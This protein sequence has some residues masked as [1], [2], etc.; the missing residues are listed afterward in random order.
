[1]TSSNAALGGVSE[2]QE[3]VCTGTAGTFT[4]TFD[5]A[6]SAAIA[7]NAIAADVKTAFEGLSTVTSATV[8]FSSGTSAC[9]AAGAN[10]M[11]ITF[12]GNAGD[13]ALVTANVA[14]LDSGAGTIAIT[15]ATAGTLG[16]LVHA[17][18]TAGSLG[19]L[20]HVEATA[21]A[22]GTLVHAETTAGSL[23]TLVH[24]E[25]TAGT[26]GTLVHAQTTAGS[27]GTL[28]HAETTAGAL[29][30]LAHAQ[31]TAGSLGTLA[32]AE[33]VAGTL[34][35]IVAAET[36]AGVLGTISIAET[37]KGIDG[38]ISVAETAKG[39][40]G[41]IAHV[42]TTKGIA[43]NGFKLTHDTETT[44]LIPFSANAA[45]V[46]AKIDAL[47]TVNTV[48]V[49]FN[50]VN[51]AACAA[52]PGVDI[53]VTFSSD[54]CDE[55][56]LTADTSTGQYQSLSTGL[57]EGAGTVTF[58]EV[59]KGTC[60]PG[61]VVDSAD[62]TRENEECSNRGICNTG[63][64]ECECSR[65]T[66]TVF[67]V[68]N[69]V[70]IATGGTF[71]LTV[72]TFTTASIAYNANAGQ[73]RDAIQAL[74]AFP[75][76]SIA[77]SFS[78]GTSAC[79]GSPGVTM[80]ITFK[81]NLGDQPPITGDATALTGTGSSI[82]GSVAE[83]QTVTCIATYGYFALTF[84]G[85]TTE[86][87][88]WDSTATEVETK[89]N[90][91]SSVVGSVS[92]AFGSSSLA[93]CA[94][95][96]G[97]GIAVTFS[98]IGN[99]ASMV[100]V[101]APAGK[102]RLAATLE[103]QTLTCT[104]NSGTFTI[105]FGSETTELINYNDPQAT[106]ANKLEAL[107]TIG[108]VSV[109][110]STGARACSTTGVGIQVMFLTEIGNQAA[111]TVGGLAQLL[112][113]AGAG[114]LTVAETTAG[115]LGTISV[116]ETVQGSG[117]GTTGTSREYN[118]TASNG[119]TA[120]MVAGYSYSDC[121]WYPATVSECPSRMIEDT[122]A[123]SKFN[124]TCSGHGH[125]AGAPT[126]RCNCTT[127]FSGAD[128][129]LRE[130]PT[131]RA[132]FDEATATNVAHA[133]GT[134]CSNRGVCDHVTGLCKCQGGFLGAACERLACAQGIGPGET[135]AKN[136]TG[137]GM[138][139][140]M[141][142][143]AQLTT[144]NGELQSYTYGATNTSATWDA[145]MIYGCHCGTGFVHMHYKPPDVKTMLSYDCS[146]V[147]CPQGDN[148]KTP[149]KEVQTLTCIGTAGTF[150]LS[151]GG[152]TTA[153]LAWDATAVTV[154]AALNALNGAIQG[155]VTVTYSTGAAACAASPGV[156][157]VVTFN[158]NGGDLAALAF[159][160]AP[161]GQTALAGGSMT[162]VET[163]KGSQLQNFEK[164]TLTCTATSGTFS[165]SFRG[166]ITSAIAFDATALTVK[167][168]LEAL[169]T[170]T[171]VN[172]VLSTG[173]SACAASPGVGIAVTFRS[174]LGDLPAVTANVAALQGGA[175]TIVIVETVKGTKDSV[176]CSEHGICNL[177][178]GVCKCFNGF[179]SS[180]HNNE[181][182]DYRDCGFMNN[183]PQARTAVLSGE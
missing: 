178:T 50:G 169:Q 24:A 33:T 7:Y 65:F 111:F 121:G 25:T 163:T 167:T 138:C 78:S 10:T 126:W 161:T 110:Y 170:I 28:A 72:L 107:T 61:I 151:F 120:G 82:V 133:D 30:S 34:G 57:Q 38:T 70:C 147:A 32:H 83:V 23:G 98:D 156:D 55:A 92:V 81:S 54:D 86:A 99:V 62:G 2:V 177:E 48:D 104:A 26:L 53:T 40:A 91:L 116:V 9:D 157:L 35:T 125:C 80:S 115:S 51:T 63:T 154:Q 67:E 27:L 68:Q 113:V 52:S 22:L 148:P 128:C 139:K 89:I 119:A 96:P 17:E 168:A 124:Y 152:Q 122:I 173:S 179:T 42:E 49:A 117:T 127:G 19:S 20:A 47:S 93:A 73:V 75:T 21:G 146:F 1:M 135:V 106:V 181:Q 3:V 87:L 162:V 97:I 182:G 166:R 64:G 44:D 155:G 4:L 43:G 74:T 84:G 176:D 5:S 46:K 108:E 85:E 174:E 140:S 103:M 109:V 14:A 95:S 56:M 144:T 79:A 175:G 66:N 101:A 29:G 165:L 150:T 15:Q 112:D 58:A 37:A 90:D 94:A 164:Q 134:E 143:L 77:V 41:T 11:T 102:T 136:C 45:T 123:G 171:E 8:V 105:S 60:P 145:H 71:T 18:T 100:A 149:T 31:T 158:G 69:L 76:D 114:T 180:D 59:T 153:V 13:L 36:V 12:T 183:N 160:L 6:T 131:G 159:D 118:F 142:Q 129:S 39:I 141:Y 88:K 130:C 137:N 172:V 132:W 16:T